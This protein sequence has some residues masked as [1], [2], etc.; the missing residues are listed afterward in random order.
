MIV[1]KFKTAFASAEC[2]KLMHQRYFG[3]RQ[4]E[5]IYW[6]GV[7]DYT[8][9]ATA[10]EEAVDEKRVDQFGDWIDEQDLP[11]DLQLKVE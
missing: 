3:G 8:M 11:D 5:C 2:M 9:A 1:V 7:T 6:D 10:A 4:L